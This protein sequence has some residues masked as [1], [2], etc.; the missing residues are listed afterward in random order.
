MRPYA[1]FS[2]VIAWT[3]VG[4]LIQWIERWVAEATRKPMNG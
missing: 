3:E 4:F 1:V 2:R